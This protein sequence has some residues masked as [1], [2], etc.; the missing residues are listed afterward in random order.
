MY[1]TCWR[2]TSARGFP[3][4]LEGDM[5]TKR[6]QFVGATVVLLLLAGAADVPALGDE[7][8]TALDRM[9]IQTATEV[10]QDPSSPES[11]LQVIEMMKLWDVTTPGLFEEQVARL[12]EPISPAWSR[13]IAGLE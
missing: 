1:R 2:G 3:E 7:E 11:V 10:I 12:E 4:F 6:L 5:K 8:D 13:E 9:L